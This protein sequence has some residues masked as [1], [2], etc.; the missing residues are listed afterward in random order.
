[1]AYLDDLTPQQLVALLEW[2]A[3]AIADPASLT[4]SARDLVVERLRQAAKG[5]KS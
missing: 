2:A 4:R 1:M 3:Q 5:V